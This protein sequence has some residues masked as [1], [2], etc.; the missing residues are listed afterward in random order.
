[1]VEKGG[2]GLFRVF[3]LTGNSNENHRKINRYLFGVFSLS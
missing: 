1:V 2:E 3:G